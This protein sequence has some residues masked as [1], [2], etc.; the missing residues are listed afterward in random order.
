M[1]S[2]D[3]DPS[4]DVVPNDL[5]REGDVVL[6]SDTSKREIFLMNE[7]C[8]CRLPYKFE[9]VKT[10]KVPRNEA[11]KMVQCGICDRWYHYNCVNL[12]V[13][14]AKRIKLAKKC[15]CAMTMD[16][17]QHSEIFSILIRYRE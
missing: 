10:K 15:G 7:Y 3:D 1:Q 6:K 2:S 5:T 4:D 14:E 8:S 11:I 16:V 9:H 17:M 12:T 13:A